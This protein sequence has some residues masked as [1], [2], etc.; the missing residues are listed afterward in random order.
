MSVLLISFFLASS[1][2]AHPRPTQHTEQATIR[3]GMHTGARY[4]ALLLT[5]LCEGD[6]ALGN[7]LPDSV[8]LRSLTTTLHPDTDVHLS[9]MEGHQFTRG[10]PPYG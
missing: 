10:L 2:S 4:T 6:D 5:L 7:G 9:K 1:M 8:D 3:W